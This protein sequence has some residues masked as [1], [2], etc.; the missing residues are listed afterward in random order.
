M[1]SL[2][3]VPADRLEGWVRRRRLVFW[4]SVCLVAAIVVVIVGAQRW[5]AGYA[6]EKLRDRV[7]TMR[8][9]KVDAERTLVLASGAHT[10]LLARAEAV[11]ALRQT[12]VLPRQ[13]TTLSRVAPPGVVFTRIESKRM[14]G[15][16]L[17]GREGRGAIPK[18]SGA[19]RGAVA[20]MDGYAVSHDELDHLINE[21]QTI[22]CWEQVRLLRAAR[23]PYQA[24][25]A[26]AFKLVCTP[27]EQTP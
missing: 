19:A 1:Q 2:N 11:V 8:A 3:L 22:P 9:R 14:R 27:A 20:E 5:A 17:R 16:P 21:L 4:M 26:I 13:L 10:E 24:G 7:T 18:P 23:E 12:H 25:E 6:I 15:A